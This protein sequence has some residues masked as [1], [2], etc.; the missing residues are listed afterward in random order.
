MAG[1]RRLGPLASAGVHPPLIFKP[2]R[3]RFELS[4]AAANTLFRECL[5]LEEAYPIR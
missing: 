2:Y 3:V 5:G 4:R 1:Q